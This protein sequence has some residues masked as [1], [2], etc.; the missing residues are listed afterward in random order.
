MII[1]N[2]LNKKK[3]DLNGSK[4]D[5]ELE[6]N[7]NKRWPE[8]DFTHSKNHGIYQKGRETIDKS[9]GLTRGRQSECYANR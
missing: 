4:P 5:L 7:K 6:I 2:E 1:V 8:V 3:C 9:L